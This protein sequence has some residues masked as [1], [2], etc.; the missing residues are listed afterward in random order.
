VD[1]TGFCGVLGLGTRT[2]R[3]MI[4]WVKAVITYRFF[5]VLLSGAIRVKAKAVDVDGVIEE[6]RRRKSSPREFIEYLLNNDS[7]VV[8]AVIEYIRDVK[9]SVVVRD[10]INDLPRDVDVRELIQTATRELTMMRRRDIKS[11][12]R[13]SLRVF[14]LFEN[15]N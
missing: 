7:D 9:L 13:Y 10:G 12:L 8:R 3:C 2:K 5:T 4:E 1:K 15:K 11:F 6:L 14:E